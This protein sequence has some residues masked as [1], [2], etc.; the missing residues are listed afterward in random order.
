MALSARPAVASAPNIASGHM[1]SGGRNVATVS[2]TPIDELSPNV[3]VHPEANYDFQGFSRG[4]GGRQQRPEP[5]R[6]IGG[7]IDTNSAT[8]VSLM[9][10]AQPD[11]QAATPAGQVKGSFHGLLSRA[12]RA[13]EGT[14]AV[15]HG[16]LQPRGASYSASL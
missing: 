9:N 11:E 15:I 13:Y 10:Q 1:P 6:N 14:S 4:G 2:Y 7:N 12:I 8:F 3:H 5:L 16:T